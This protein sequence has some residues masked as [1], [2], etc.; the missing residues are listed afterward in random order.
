MEE[1]E[2][3][4]VKH[5]FT[6]YFDQYISDINAQV[7]LYNHPSGATLISVSNDDENKSFGVTLRTMPASSNGIA[8]ILEHAVLCGS[9]RYPV[10]SPFNELL[11][12]SV[13]TFLNAMTYPDKT[14]YPVASTNLKDLYNLV[15]VYMD[16]V[17]HPLISE[18]TL[19]QEGWR[20]EFDDNQQLTYKGIVYNEMKGAS[21]TAERITGRALYRE[22]LPD[23]IYAHDSGGNPRDIP[24]LTHTEF[25]DFHTTY[26]HP[27]NALIFW[28]GDDPE[29]ERLEHLEP[30]LSDFE[31]QVPPPPI[32]PQAQWQTSRQARYPYPASPEEQRHHVTVAWL[33]DE[34]L[35]AVDEMELM[36]IDSALLGDAAAP[37]RKKLLD[38]NLGD[39]LTG[40]G[41]G[42]GLQAYFALGLKGVQEADVAAVEPLVRTAIAEVIAEGIEAE[43]LQAAI[44]TLEFRYRENNTGGFPR[45]LSLMLAISEPWLYGIDIIESMRFEAP[46]AEVKARLQD[47]A[48]PGQLLQRMLLDNPHQLT[49]IVYPDAELNARLDAEEQDELATVAAQLDDT[50]RQHIHDTAAQLKIWQETPD[51]PEALARIPRLTR[52]DIEA[53]IKTTPLDFTTHDGIS[54]SIAPLFTSGVAYVSMAFDLL[55]VPM[56]LV[57]YIPLYARALTETGAAHMD[58]SRL[59]QQ[60]GI[61]TGGIGASS[62]VGTHRTTRNPYGVMQVQGK[63]TVDNID[64]LASL[65]RDIVVSPHLHN[66]ERI[67]QMIREDK[68][69]RE[70]GLLPSGHVYIN[71]RL[72]A[73]FSVANTYAEL[74]GGVTYMHFI[75][76]LARRGDAAW[77]DVSQALQRIHAAL[78]HRQGLRIHVTINPELV[79]PVMQAFSNVCASIPV[80]NPD[81]HPWQK[82]TLAPREGLIAPAQVNYVG[83]GATLADI[84]YACDGS[85]IVVNRH[86]SR[87]FL[88]DQVR[89]QGGAYGVFSVLDIRS[90]LLTM[91]SYRDPN[92][93]KTLDTYRRAGEW[94]QAQTL[95]D[96]TLLQAIIGAIGD[97]DGHQLPDA[98]GMSA[99]MRHLSGD[100]DNYRQQVRNRILAVTN[101]DFARYGAA[102]TK[103]TAEWRCVILGGENALTADLDLAQRTTVLSLV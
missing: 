23:T 47:P 3:A 17:F 45:G 90:G 12:G 59:S 73:P 70:A 53:T 22:L 18:N 6:C 16:A 68:A 75:R 33:I 91:L 102:I 21:A 8:H 11:K 89:E 31:A 19:R 82:L 14:V 40:G 94:L 81:P 54:W 32:A 88:H 20:Y 5:Q 99:F 66:K 29:G 71:N 61:Y 62:S 58:S 97:I 64:T 72:R 28:Y 10:K 51:A 101:A 46:L 41:F 67:M 92:T 44:N 55:N 1:M 100:D 103:L 83:I 30:F 63:A 13:N 7:R 65:M 38:S 84:G 15:S 87:T 69:G 52:E 48:R 78:M 43:Q 86:L 98:R 96:D 56:D 9:K 2:G 60:M 95:D 93:H 36:I 35:S 57:Q 26:Y 50:Q 27:S 39:N 49:L 79:D 4:S 85:D 34:H 74:V 25:V 80:G 24:S 77:D 42:T 37:L 76:E